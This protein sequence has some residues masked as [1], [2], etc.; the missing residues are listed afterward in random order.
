MMSSAVLACLALSAMGQTD[1]PPILKPKPQVKR[2]TSTIKPAPAAQT[3][4]LVTCD[5]ACVWKLDGEAKGTIDGGE[6]TKV[7]LDAGTH[8]INARTTDGA[9]KIQM[10][11]QVK[12]GEQSLLRLELKPIRQARLQAEGAAHEQAAREQAAHE[13]A[14]REQGALEQ[15]LREQEVRWPGERAQLLKEHM[16]LE[17]ALKQFAGVS[18]P[19]VCDSH[20]RNDLQACLDKGQHYSDGDGVAKN[21]FLAAALW[22]HNCN[23]GSFNGCLRAGIEFKYGA[24]VAKDLVAAAALYRMGCSLD[25]HGCDYL[26]EMYLNGSGVPQDS[27]R[28]IDIDQKACAASSDSGGACADLADIYWKGAPGVPQDSNKAIWIVRDSCNKGNTIWSCDK[29]KEYQK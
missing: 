20:S 3:W 9:D 7:R 2:Q 28:A 19:E 22:I 10:E 16:A 25:A 4:L 14:A 17:E 12:A 13:R 27:F 6:S 15:Y 18:I 11:T 21:K 5:L 24:G 26:A 1:G 23:A 29:L 8:L